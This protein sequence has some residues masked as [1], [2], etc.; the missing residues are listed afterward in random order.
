[1]VLP[2]WTLL[3]VTAT[4]DVDGEVRAWWCRRQGDETAPEWLVFTG[5][6]EVVRAGCDVAVGEVVAATA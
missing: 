5:E 3:D 2:Q 1:V 6:A 4:H